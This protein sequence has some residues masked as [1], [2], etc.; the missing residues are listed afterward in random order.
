MTSCISMSAV[1][2]QFINGVERSA[3]EYLEPL[4]RTI[5]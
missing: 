2:S 1:G 3:Q 4:R 5:S